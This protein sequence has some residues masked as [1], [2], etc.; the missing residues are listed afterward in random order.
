MYWLDASCRTSIVTLNTRAV[1]VMVEAA[2]VLRIVRVLSAS[3]DTTEGTSTTSPSAGVR[4][5][6][7]TARTAMAKGTTNR[8]VASRS[9]SLI[10]TPPL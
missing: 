1:R 10:P 3:P 2:M 9:R 6:R 4:N 5:D 7:A 8:L